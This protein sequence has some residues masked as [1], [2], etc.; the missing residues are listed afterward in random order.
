L[1]AEI[2]LDGLSCDDR[3]AQL[4]L[5]L[6]EFVDAGPR[7]ML[8]FNGDQALTDDDAQLLKYGVVPSRPLVLK[9]SDA[10][11]DDG[12]GFI[13]TLPVP[14]LASWRSFASSNRFP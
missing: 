5:R 6:C 12:D 13:G 10:A 7:Q 4:K 11:D 1:C 2:R 9:V 14:A 8:L 3:V